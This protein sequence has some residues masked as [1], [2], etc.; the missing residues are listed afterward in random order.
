MAIDSY[1]ILMIA[2]TSFFA[3]YGCHVRILEEIR[4]LQKRGHIVELC[5]YHNG[6]DIEGIPIHRTVDIPWRKRVVVGSSKHK[7]YLDVALFATAL[8]HAR[9]FKPDIIHAHLH[10]GALIG[11][12]AG[13]LAGA[14]VVFDYQGSLTEEMMD[15]GFIPRSGLRARLFR[16]LESVI[17]RL[18]DVILP[19][20]RAAETHLRGRH[21]RLPD[22][23]TISD[24]VDLD[25]FDPERWAS[26][27]QAERARLGIPPDAPVV[28]YLG[29]LADYQGTPAL[30]E[31][32]SQL[33][34]R[35]RDAYVVI[36]GYPGV[37]RHAAMAARLPHTERIL[38][39]GRIP[40]EDAPALLSIGDAAAAPK[41]SATEAN[42]KILNYM[43]MRL[44]T[45]CVDN[46]VN[47]DLLGDLGYYVPPDDPA[48]LAHQLHRA[49]DAPE[50]MRDALRQRVTARFS[51]DRQI[52]EIE[53]I[54]AALLSGLPL[55]APAPRPSPADSLG[56]DD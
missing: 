1:R 5:T 13:K 46:T 40:Y 38:F 7:M 52:R 39:P 56:S 8:R 12:F 24:A 6:R 9:R 55:A 26:A 50:L 4:A 27:R 21:A 30:I 10:E 37:G 36:A 20:S 34:E 54:Y 43:A 18:P 32:A 17:D 31:A 33:L 23:R 42:G 53:R 45:V 15:H 41:R 25:R 51:W 16:K 11:A 3:D 28:V 49:L 48:A 2:P 22:V 44:P 35:R 14:P 19:S 47:R 29:L